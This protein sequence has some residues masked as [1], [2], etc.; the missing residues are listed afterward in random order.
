[1]CIRVCLVN[2]VHLGVQSLMVRKNNTSFNIC[3]CVL[4]PDL[5]KLEEPSMRQGLCE[6]QEKPGDELPGTVI[7][8][9]ILSS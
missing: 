6:I 5:R 2:G 9:D 8:A 7:Y 1:M 3:S 4:R